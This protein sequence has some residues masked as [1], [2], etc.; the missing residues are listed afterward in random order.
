[1]ESNY[2]ALA[3]ALPYQPTFAIAGLVLMLLLSLVVIVVIVSV[4]RF[5]Y[6][7]LKLPEQT[8]GLSFWRSMLLWSICFSC[9]IFT[10]LA[11]VIYF[12]PSKF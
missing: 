1:M 11:F 9:L 3:E 2:L 12:F 7:K 5:Y 10:L 8:A 4:V 6:I